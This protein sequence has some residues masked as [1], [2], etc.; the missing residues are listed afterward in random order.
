MKNLIYLFCFSLLLISCGND[1]DALIEDPLLNNSPYYMTFT[2]AGNNYDSRASIGV[3]VDGALIEDPNFLALTLGVD[4][5]TNSGEILAVIVTLEGDSSDGFG[6]GFEINGSDQN[7]ILNFVYAKS[8]LSGNVEFNGSAEDDSE[9]VF[10]KITSID[11]D[12]KIITGNFSFTAV[13]DI[14]TETRTVSNGF[15]KV[16][17]Q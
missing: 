10:F 8:N 14:S 15:F 5:V 2:E 4:F 17:Y 12:N 3:G 9:P 16:N 11:R 7:Y 13:S 1:D 6:S